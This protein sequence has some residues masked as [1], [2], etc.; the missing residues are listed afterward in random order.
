MKREIDLSYLAGIIDGEGTV[1]INH[2]NQGNIYRI[3]LV[4]TNTNKSLMDWLVKN[5]GGNV[6]PRGPTRTK[7][8]Q[9]YDWYLLG[10][11]AYHLLKSI[12]NLLLIK[13]EQAKICIR[14]Y[15]FLSNKNFNRRNTRSVSILEFQ[16]RLCKEIRILN[17][18]GI[19]IPQ[20]TKIEPQTT[21]LKFEKLR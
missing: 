19:C 8:K 21:I 18:R 14:Y 13:N 12:E 11:K 9:I 7:V 15:E 2:I 16:K 10:E 5:F 6:S 3:F 4:V 20:E 17:N 1:T